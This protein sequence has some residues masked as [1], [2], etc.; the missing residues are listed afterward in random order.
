LASELKIDFFI[1]TVKISRG[2]PRG[3]SIGPKPTIGLQKASFSGE[4]AAPFN[5]LGEQP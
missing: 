5:R 1:L 2:L 3:G 4:V